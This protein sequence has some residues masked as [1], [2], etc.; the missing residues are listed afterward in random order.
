MS[1]QLLRDIETI[2]TELRATDEPVDPEELRRVAR[3]QRAEDYL[4]LADLLERKLQPPIRQAEQFL[5]IRPNE[6]VERAERRGHV[7]DWPMSSK[8][9][10]ADKPIRPTLDELYRWPDGPNLKQHRHQDDKRNPAQL[11]RNRRELAVIE[12]APKLLSKIREVWGTETWDGE[13][14]GEEAAN[15]LRRNLEQLTPLFQQKIKSL[16]ERANDLLND[17]GEEPQD[18]TV[19][20]QIAKVT[21][22]CEDHMQSLN[23]NDTLY[24]YTQYYHAE[25]GQLHKRLD[26]LNIP[27][28]LTARVLDRAVSFKQPEKGLEHK[29]YGPKFERYR[30]ETNQTGDQVRDM[31]LLTPV[32]KINRKLDEGRAPPEVIV[33]RFLSGGDSFLSRKDS[34]RPEELPIADKPSESVWIKGAK[35][36]LWSEKPGPDTIAMLNRAQTYNTEWNVKLKD[37]YQATPGERAVYADGV[38]RKGGR[39]RP[40]VMAK[41]TPE[42]RANLEHKMQIFKDAA[43]RGRNATR[44]YEGIGH[45]ASSIVQTLKQLERALYLTPTGHLRRTQIAERINDTMNNLNHLIDMH[46]GAHPDEPQIPH[47][48]REIY[49]DIT[50]GE[51][52]DAG[53]D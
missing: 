2:R 4:N 41:S 32:D 10:E 6:E 14:E 30:R 37:I 9:L 11:A 7:S 22:R 48:T 50:I 35:T 52:K 13:P 49:D 20:S 46:N 19:L 5:G 21:Q 38:K 12:G 3:I 39:Y 31:E 40:E 27:P 26:D 17:R 33:R 8:P 24:I 42:E 25:I 53:F 44:Q 45:E 16:R 29:A 51:H 15:R 43:Q 36:F 1:D 28:L 23:E 47:I 34:Y 18:L